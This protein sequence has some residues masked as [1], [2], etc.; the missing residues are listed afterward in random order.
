[1]PITDAQRTAFLAAAHTLCADN[2][3]TLLFLTVFGSHLYGTDAPGTSDMDLRGIFLPSLRSLAL[4]ASRRSLHRSTGDSTRRNAPQDVDMDL[5][6]LQHWLL[7]LL[8]DGDTGALDLLFAPSH[9]ACTIYRSPLLHAVFA[10]PKRLVNMNSGKSYAA[11]SLR[12]ARKYGIK[13]SRLGALRRA[14]HWL[15]DNDGRFHAADRLRPWINAIVARC[16]D[17]RFCRIVETRDGTA[18][19]LCGKLHMGSVRMEEFSRRVFADMRRYGE[20]AQEAEHDRGIDFKA[21]SHAVRAL[22]QMEELLRTGRVMFPLQRRETLRTIKRGERSWRELEPCII[23]KLQD[24]ET[25]QSCA[26]NR[27]R[28]EPDFARRCILDCYGML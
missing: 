9:E 5:W 25:L 18:L 14:L 26:P 15:Q 21:L 4:H 28:H 16:D 11:Y 27:G 3:A 12:Q 1:M 8:P 7:R 19:N 13:G 2:D 23:A 20:S 17:A 24:V 10:N 6:S 22:C